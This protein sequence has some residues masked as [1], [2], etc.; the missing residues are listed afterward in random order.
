MAENDQERTERPTR[1]RIEEARQE[2]QV[3]RSAELNAAAVLL[4]A[5]GSLHF[6]GGSLGGA[7]FDIIKSGLSV[8]PA[9]AVDPGLALATAGTRAGACAHGLRAGLRPD[10]ARRAA[11][12]LRRRRLESQLRGA[13]ARLHASRPVR[14][15]AAS[16][17]PEAPSSSARLSRNS[18]S[19]PPSRWRYCTNN[20][21]SF[22]R[23][24]PRRCTRAS[25][26]PRVSP[27]NAL[28]AVSGGLV[29]IAA[30]DVPWQL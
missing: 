7:L 12:A 24:G 25:R 26:T 23:S 9:V 21:R 8:A 17:P 27:A 18:W 13:G 20:R 15:S 29:L 14:A 10:A 1:K 22:S 6:L 28:L 3:P 2:G 19:S 30:V 4:V 16:S 11:G 5:A